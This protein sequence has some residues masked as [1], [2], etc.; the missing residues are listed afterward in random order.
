MSQ[1]DVSARLKK[2]PIF[3][4]TVEIGERMLSAVELPDYA[5]ALNL[6]PTELFRRMLEVERSG[7]PIPRRVDARKRRKKA[8]T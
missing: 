2:R 1:R 8:K 7:A 5:Q 3:A 6:D 4:H